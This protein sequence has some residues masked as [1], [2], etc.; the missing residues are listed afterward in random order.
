MFS[1]ISIHVNDIVDA[2]E[3]RGFL[4]GAKPAGA[5]S[6]AHDGVFWREIKAEY[7]EIVLVGRKYRETQPL[8]NPLGE[9]DDLAAWIVDSSCA[10]VYDLWEGYNE[11]PRHQLDARCQFDVR[12]AQRLHAAGLKYVCGSWSV[13][14]PDIPD[15]L[16]P[17][18]LDVLRAADA[19]GVHEYCAPRMDDPRG[20]DLGTVRNLVALVA[21]GLQASATEDLTGWFTLRWRKWY[22][23]LPEDCR[24]PLIVSE[25]G[26]DSGA[27]HWDPGAQ[28]G[29]RS[30]TDVPGY[31]EQLRWYD[32][33]LMRDGVLLATIFC[34][35]AHD[36]TWATF[37]VSGE[38]LAALG[39][40]IEST[41]QV[42]DAW[43]ALMLAKMEEL[44][45]AASSVATATAEAGQA[46]VVLGQRVAELGTLMEQMPSSPDVSGVG[47]AL[48]QGIAAIT[49]AVDEAKR[50][51]GLG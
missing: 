15:W 30:F 6:L 2:D 45:A 44:R 27:C 7:P 25:C 21:P 19:I 4:L 39:R 35:Q 9:A 23:T 1:R 49:G 16:L 14:V 37:N 40:Y 36:P 8:S 51:L 48:D 12:M 33:Y 42:E 29:W 17:Q 41:H 32:S 46:V 34:C 31:L 43:K 50:L 10:G 5:K 47:V 20:L 38:M 24:K 3:L 11:T 22:P 13:G 26:I 18:M 28:G